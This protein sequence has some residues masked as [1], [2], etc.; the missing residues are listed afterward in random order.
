MCC[1]EL[2]INNSTCAITH[3]FFCHRGSEA[4][5]EIKRS[6]YG[7]IIILIVLLIII[8]LSKIR[9]MIK[10]MKQESYLSPYSPFLGR[11]RERGILL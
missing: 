4:Q 1:I 7:R 5:S 9:I 2:Q 10:I 3:L 11:D 6:F 8:V